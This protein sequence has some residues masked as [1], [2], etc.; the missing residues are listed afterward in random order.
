MIRSILCVHISDE[1]IGLAMAERGSVQNEVVSLD[2]IA[3]KGFNKTTFSHADRYQQK[4][5]IYRAVNDVVDEFGICAFVVG[6][7]VQ[8]DGRPGSSCGRVLHII[9]F[10]CGTLKKKRVLYCR[11]TNITSNSMFSFPCIG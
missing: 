8:P 11:I 7:P 10:L 2:S 5:R 6:W 9:D 3:H 1:N 4:E